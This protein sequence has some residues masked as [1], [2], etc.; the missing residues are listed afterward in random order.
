MAAFV[1][2]IFIFLMVV[3]LRARIFVGLKAQ[4]L[5]I[6]LLFSVFLSKRLELFR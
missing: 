6:L 1:K 2:S 3:A 5:M 4:E